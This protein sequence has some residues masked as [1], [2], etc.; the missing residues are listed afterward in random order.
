M[1]ELVTSGGMLRFASQERGGKADG[2]DTGRGREKRG[3][4]WSQLVWVLLSS[5]GMMESGWK[6]HLGC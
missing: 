1:V 5:S 6:Q 4:R 3:C 2:S